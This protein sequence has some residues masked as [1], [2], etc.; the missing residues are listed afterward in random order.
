MSVTVY[1]FYCLAV[2]PFTSFGFYIIK[3]VPKTEPNDQF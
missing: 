2:K 1:V 3:K